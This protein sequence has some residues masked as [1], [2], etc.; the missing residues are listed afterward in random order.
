MPS[1]RLELTTNIDAPIE[2]VWAHMTNVSKYA[3]WNPF[4]IE[5][6]SDG[7]TNRPGTVLSFRVKWHDGGYA[8]SQERVS[9]VQPVHKVSGGAQEAEWWYSFHSVFTRIGMIKTLRK[10]SLRQ[11]QGQA[12]LYSNEFVMTGWGS[13]VAPWDKIELGMKAQAQAMKAISEQN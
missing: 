12:T 10:Q 11:A 4:V 6:Q 8:N 1:K 2:L 9:H 5:A 13:G 3:T 7:D